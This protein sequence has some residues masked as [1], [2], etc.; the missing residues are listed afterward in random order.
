MQRNTLELAKFELAMAK[1]WKFYILVEVSC[2]HLY[3]TFFYHHCSMSLKSRKILYLLT[4]L[5]MTIRFLLNFIP[6]FF[7]FFVSRSSKPAS[8][9]SKA[10]VNPFSIHGPHLVII[11][12][13]LLLPSLVRKFPWING[14]TS[15]VIQLLLSLVKLSNSIN[16]SCVH[17]RSILFVLRVNKEKVTVSISV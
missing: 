17:P 16:C 8:C 6:L 3:T 2:L 12:P 5:H 14:I 11:F 10:Q 13:S 7:F 9:S 15:W 4:S 1:V